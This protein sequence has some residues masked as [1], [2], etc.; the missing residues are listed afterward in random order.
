MNN[1]I[2]CVY[3][4]THTCYTYN[5]IYIYDVFIH[6]KPSETLWTLDLIERFLGWLTWILVGF[7]NWDHWAAGTWCRFIHDINAPTPIY[8][9]IY[10]YIRVCVYIYIYT[11][12]IYIYTHTYMCGYIF[13]YA[14]IQDWHP[15]QT[16]HNISLH[17]GV[18]KLSTSWFTWLTQIGGEDLR[19]YWHVG[20]VWKC[21]K[22]HNIW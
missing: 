12:Y 10:V 14:S 21:R 7:R 9:Y 2:H 19:F 20:L 16:F 11:R 6:I 17:R 4:Y 13:M 8:V 3:I 18:L 22:K 15:M 5:Y 1:D